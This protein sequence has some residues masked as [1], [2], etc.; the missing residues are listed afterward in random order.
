MAGGGMASGGMEA[1]R[2]A[3]TGFES[4]AP[5]MADNAP[6]LSDDTDFEDDIPF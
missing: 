4:N 3:P 1:P 6:T 5:A 2:G